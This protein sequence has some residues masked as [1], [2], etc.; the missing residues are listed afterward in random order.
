MWKM[1]FWASRAVNCRRKW[2]W[3][4]QKLYLSNLL[5]ETYLTPDDSSNL[6]P[7]W[8]AVSKALWC[9]LT[10]M[11]KGIFLTAICWWISGSL[12]IKSSKE[13]RACFHWQSAADTSD[14][15][16]YI[17]GFR[18]KAKRCK[19]PEKNHQTL[20][21]HLNKCAEKSPRIHQLRSCRYHSPAPANT[22]ARAA[23]LRAGVCSD[24]QTSPLS[25]PRFYPQEPQGKAGAA[26][27][28]A[29]QS[30][31]LCIVPWRFVSWRW[32]PALYLCHAS[33]ATRFCSAKLSHSLFF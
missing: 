17:Q 25:P 15:P 1:P 8:S 27:V 9:S 4:L 19:E 12:Q 29:F 23:Q 31:P 10:R 2:Y 3:F 5:N 13:S 21:L 26:K 14:I 6:I 7:E 18:S 24:F 32:S 33:G 28:F 11:M 22:C 20:Q 16:E 30:S